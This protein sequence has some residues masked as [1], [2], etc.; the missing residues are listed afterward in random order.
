MLGKTLGVDRM[1]GRLIKLMCLF[2]CKKVQLENDVQKVILE[3]QADCEKLNQSTRSL[4]EDIQEKQRHIQVRGRLC[5]LF[6]TL[7]KFGDI[8]ATKVI[9]F[10][11]M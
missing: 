3:L 1:N 6:L 11:S 2:I 4:H 9:L 8:Y 10:V 5:C 7:K